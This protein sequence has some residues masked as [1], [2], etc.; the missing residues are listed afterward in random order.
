MLSELP[1]PLEDFVI[2]KRDDF[3]FEIRKSR[4]ALDFAESQFAEWVNY[5][6]NKLIQEKQETR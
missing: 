4:E 5:L 2:I 3:T 1:S 6:R